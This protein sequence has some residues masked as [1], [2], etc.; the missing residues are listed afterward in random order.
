MTTFSPITSTT[1]STFVSGTLEESLRVKE[2]E[3]ELD[4]LRQSTI[5]GFNQLLELKDLSTGVHSCRL[6]EWAVVLAGRLGLDRQ[7]Q[8]D[9]KTAALL[10]DLGKIGIPDAILHKPGALAPEE[11]VIINK[12]PEYGWSALRMIPGFERVSLFVRH[13]HERVDGKGYPAG[14]KG[15]EIPL[16]S[17][18]VCVM[19]A[20]DAMVSNRCYRKGLPIEEALRRLKT[21]GGSQFDPQVVKHFLRIIRPNM[22]QGLSIRRPLSV[23]QPMRI[24]GNYR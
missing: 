2:L 20:F 18:I 1:P 7:T 21:C 6:A 24:A 13:H 15:E 4:Q 22:S 9:V 14:L 17:R 23:G 19:D 5:S 12:H 3:E 8:Q 10:H 11:R 16:G